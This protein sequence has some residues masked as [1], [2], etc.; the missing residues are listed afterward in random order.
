[1]ITRREFLGYMGASAAL[2]LAAP[3]LGLFQPYLLEEDFRL[4]DLQ[5]TSNSATSPVS[6]RA[7]FDYPHIGG[8]MTFPPVDEDSQR[9]MQLLEYLRALGFTHVLYGMGFDASHF[10]RNRDGHWTYNGGKYRDGE[11]AESLRA[12]K[13]AVESLDMRLI[14]INGSLTYVMNQIGM[15]PSISEFRSEAA[16]EKWVK[17]NGLPLRLVKD[18]PRGRIAYVGKNPGMDDLFIENLRIIRKNWNWPA[19]T[20][21]GG[22][23]PEYIHIGHDEIGEYW[24]CAIKADRSKHLSG[25]RSQLIAR[26]INRRVRQVRSVLG[27]GTQVMIFG[28][29]LLPADHGETYGLIGDSETGNGGVLRRL[30][31]RYGLANKIIVMPW[32]YSSRD[33][34]D[35]AQMDQDGRILPFSKVRQLAYLNRLGIRYMP[36][37][38]EDGAVPLSDFG[39]IQR[40]LQTTFEWVRA[41]QMYPAYLVGF[42]HLGWNSG[43]DGASCASDSG[44]CTS[45]N[46]S[47]LAYLAWTYG[48]R[49]LR[50]ARCNSYGGRILS[51]VKP[52]LSS[53]QK[54]WIEGIHYYPPPLQGTLLTRAGQ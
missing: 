2:A 25:T 52:G 43:V 44:Y 38:G 32:I 48:E 29:S 39:S 5:T 33:G 34:L 37:T 13:A 11:V 14:P 53:A 10:T 17:R 50:I 16:F 20:P 40:T 23:M 21:L 24:A 1:M 15:D 22:R 46:A 47:W 45:Y 30:R 27:E 6:I 19:S 49:S 3:K 54:A 8:R 31:D 35:G 4:S 28:D 9:C 51:R 7:A 36:G 26:E 12:M 18:F 41:S 42:A